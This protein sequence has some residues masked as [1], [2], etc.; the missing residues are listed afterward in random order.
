MRL[1]SVY[2]AGTG[3]AVKYAKAYLKA[4]G[5]TITD[6]EPD[7]VL[8]DVPTR[9]GL[10]E[11]EDLMEVFPQS[12]VV[13][14]G[15]LP[16]LPCPQLDLLKD[17]EYLAENAAITAECALRVVGEQLPSVLREN[18]ILI[19]GWGRIGKC[20]ADL[21]GRFG[22]DVT[23]TAR[24]EVDVATLHSLGFRADTPDRIRPGDYAAVINTAPAVVYDEAE[25]EGCKLKIDLASCPGILGDDVIIARGLPG[26]YVPESSG[27]LIARRLLALWKEAK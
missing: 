21:L 13:C 24:K 15:N 12:T 11:L 8:L 3:A 20:L 9:L 10:R 19:I 22:A 16:V 2:P 7:V 6:Q 18:T 17:T 4:E 14:G 1:P 23:V 26:K 5:C 27:R 25:L